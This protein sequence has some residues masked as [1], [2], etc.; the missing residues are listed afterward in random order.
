MGNIDPG[1]T[2]SCRVWNGTKRPNCILK[3]LISCFRCVWLVL[4]LNLLGHRSSRINVPHPWS[5]KTTLIYKVRLKGIDRWKIQILSSSLFPNLY[6]IYLFS[7]TH[8]HTHTHTNC[9]LTNGYCWLPCL[10]KQTKQKNTEIQEDPTGESPMFGVTWEWLCDDRI[11]IFGWAISLSPNRVNTCVIGNFIKLHCQ[12]RWNIKGIIYCSLRS[13]YIYQYF[14]I[15][16]KCISN[17]LFLYLLHQNA[18]IEYAWRIVDSE[19]N[20]HCY[21]WLK[22][23]HVYQPKSFTDGRMMQWFRLKARKY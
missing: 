6:G 1:G 23:V 8:T 15:Y 2:L 12:Y 13:T 19:V 18:L 14:Y 5:N 20:A 7:R 3:T 17:N 4:E 11:S 21:D 22:V 9:I 16:K 10:D